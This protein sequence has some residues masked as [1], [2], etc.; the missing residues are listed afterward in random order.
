MISKALYDRWMSEM[1]ASTSVIPTHVPQT[2]A[3]VPGSMHASTMEAAPAPQPSIAQTAPP[4]PVPTT[5][6]EARS[7]TKEEPIVAASPD[8]IRRGASI[9]RGIEN[10][11][12]Q[13]ESGGALD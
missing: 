2:P 8:V 6:V 7:A 13:L 4:P 10:K 5:K 9:H 1:I 12:G 11:S 3:L